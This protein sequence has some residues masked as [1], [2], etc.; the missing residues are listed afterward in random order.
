MEAIAKLKVTIDD[1]REAFQSEKKRLEIENALLR[2]LVRPTITRRDLFAAAVTLG[3]WSNP[4]TFS[5][6]AD[7][8]AKRA[9]DL[10]TALDAPKP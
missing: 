6:G 5:C 8:L 3:Y 9:D 7:V 1:E 2:E 10:I 4:H